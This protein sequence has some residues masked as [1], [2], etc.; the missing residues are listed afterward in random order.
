M[1]ILI[2]HNIYSSKGGEEGVV[3]LQE[4]LLRSKGH[5]VLLYTRE[6]SEM[7][8][9]LLGRFGGLFTSIHNPKSHRDLKKIISSFKP[10]IAILHNLFPIISPSIIPLLNKN[11][12]PTWQIVHN[13]RL[14]CPIGIFYTKGEI[15]QECLGFGREWNCLKNNC[16]GSYFASLSLAI[17]GLFT[18]KLKYYNKVDYFYTL[19]LFQKKKLID[20]GF[21]V[22]KIRNL[23]NTFMPKQKVEEVN[24]EEKEYIGFVGRLTKEKGLFDFIEIAR[25][26]PEYSFRVA[27]ER[28]KES[29]NLDFPSNIKF[30]GFLNQKQ[31]A[32]FYKKTKLILFLSRWYEGF[33]L[34]LLEAMYNYTPIIVN[35]LSV[36]AEVVEDR[37]QG[38]VV[39]I[40]DTALI[41]KYIEEIYNNKD[42]YKELSFNARKRF[43]DNYSV[44]NY[45]NRL[46]KTNND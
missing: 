38:F 8:K 21:A 4:K 27:G 14:L 13:Y 37:K 41:K 11:K 31:M 46:M 16:T 20:N 1:N 17:R 33:P 39:E 34:V 10:D 26:M 35:N 44:E 22:D 7:K 29:E 28:T 9:W 45:Y 43:E 23:P 3:E 6:Y 40:G 30:E 24:L 36:M 18:R 2:I 12:I 19:S 25:Q 5:N 42:L 32:E 15:C